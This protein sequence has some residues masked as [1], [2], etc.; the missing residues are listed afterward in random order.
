[1]NIYIH[2]H[3]LTNKNLS[4][5]IP[6]SELTNNTTPHLASFQILWHYKDSRKS[7]SIEHQHAQML[8][9]IS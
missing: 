9:N 8:S 6:A 7:K 2:S 3:V 4:E 1:M 5:R